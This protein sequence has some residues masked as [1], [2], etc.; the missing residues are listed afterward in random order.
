LVDGNYY[1]K[2]VKQNVNVIGLI[3][4]YSIRNKE[5]KELIFFKYSPYED[6]NRERTQ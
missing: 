6:W 1:A 2:M 5:D 4:N 3:K